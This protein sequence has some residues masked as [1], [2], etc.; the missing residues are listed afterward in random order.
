[1]SRAPTDLGTLDR[2]SDER[3]PAM[4]EQRGPVDLVLVEF[5]G[6]V[7]VSAVTDALAAITTNDALRLL[8]LL[9]LSKDTE[10]EISVVEV[11]DHD[12][13]NTA[14]SLLEPGILTEEDI[15]EFTA[16]LPVGSAAL[17]FA[18]EQLWARDLTDSLAAAG[19]VSITELRIP[20]EAVAAAVAS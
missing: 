16:E 7:P 8:D 14:F 17:L 5:D 12:D 6:E 9:L 18:V 19:G 2:R 3:I 1:V 10:T 11:E 20:A 13:L 15:A 4:S